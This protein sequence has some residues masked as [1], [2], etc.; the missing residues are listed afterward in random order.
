MPYV[1]LEKQSERSRSELQRHL[2]CLCRLLGSCRLCQAALRENS[3]LP[4]PS[5]HFYSS[6]SFCLILIIIFIFITKTTPI[7][8]NFQSLE[9]ILSYLV[10]YYS[11]Y[12]TIFVNMLQ[13]QGYMGFNLTSRCIATA[14]WKKLVWKF[15]Q[16]FILLKRDVV[17]KVG[18]CFRQYA[19]LAFIGYQSKILVSN[20]GRLPKLPGFDPA[21]HEEQ[22]AVH[23]IAG[24]RSLILALATRC[25]TKF[26]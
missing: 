26:N 15:C 9:G 3:N 12:M 22:P 1:P 11:H 6:A 19:F 13:S 23:K 10:I 21:Q 18:Y 17:Q 2:K 7:I 20:K 5:N 25:E 4:Q 16:I 8:F 14:L 24:H